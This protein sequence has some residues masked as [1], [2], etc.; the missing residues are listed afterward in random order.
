MRLHDLLDAVDVLE[1]SRPR[2][3]AG[4]RVRHRPRQS[5]DATRARCSAA[6]PAR[7]PTA[8]TMRP[9]AVERG[10]VALLV[11]RP[12]RRG[13]PG[14]GARGARA[15]RSGGGAVLRRSVARDAGARRH[16]HERQDHD[17][18]P[19]RGDRSRGRRRPA[20]S[21]PRRA[22]RGRR[23]RRSRSPRPRRRELQALLA[24]AA[25]ARCDTVAMEV[26]LARARRARVDGTG[27]RSTCFTNLS[28]DH[29]DEHGTLDDY[30]EA[31]AR[32]FTP[33]FTD[34]RRDRRRRP[35][36][37]S[38]SPARARDAGSRC[39]TFGLDAAGR[40]A[41]STCV[42]LDAD[43]TTVRLDARRRR[44]PT[45]VRPAPGRFNVAE[46]AGRGRDRARRSAFDAR[47]GRSR[48]RRRSSVPG[49]MERGRSAAAVHGARRLRA[50]AR[51]RR[52][53]LVDGAGR[54]AA[55]PGRRGVRLRRRPRPGE[56]GRRWA[57]PPAAAPTSWCSRCDNPRSED[58]GAIA[59]M[60]AGRARR[61]RRRLHGRARPA[62]RD[63]RR[64]RR[65]RRPATSS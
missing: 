51:R 24:D 57:R 35:R 36:G 20:S 37:A 61:R 46:H 55:G 8:T 39:S 53:A 9:A 64:A 3:L 22:D 52:T 10:A 16:R 54:L 21:A 47:R 63:P 31:K 58:P 23:R 12:S 49:R 56:A 7:T 1:L 6:S 50:H 48:A 38:S 19:P 26:E 28:Q 27:S 32:L 33:A 62:G 43:G 25:A 29:L 15:R 14:A 18:V 45:S 40:R 2:G 59:A 65:R 60:A 11:E 44:R 5:R 41:R 4:R 34:A 17:H 42:A 13:D 30:F